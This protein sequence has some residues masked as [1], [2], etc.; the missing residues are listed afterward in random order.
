MVV[1]HFLP[2]NG[3]AM[4]IAARRWCGVGAAVVLFLEMIGV[5]SPAPPHG[6][7]GNTQ[8]TRSAT[9]AKAALPPGTPNDNSELLTRY[10]VTCHND[11]VKA[12]RLTLSHADV[13]HVADNPELWEKVAWKVRIGAMPKVPAPRP[14]KGT[15]DRFVSDLETA[16]DRA[17]SASPDPGRPTLHRLNRPCCPPMNRATAS[18]TAKGYPLPRPC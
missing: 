17:A 13:S 18:T 16:L 6:P 14:D 9:Q 5:A 15:L 8:S 10:C 4:L 2:K 1:K 7:V 3:P 12:G 11:T